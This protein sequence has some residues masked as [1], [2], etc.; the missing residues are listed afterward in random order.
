MV[1]RDDAEETKRECAIH[2]ATDEF[3]SE[4][5]SSALRDKDME[6]SEYAASKMRCP[7]EKT[8]ALREIAVRYYEDRDIVAGQRTAAAAAKYLRE[9]EEGTG[10]ARVSLTLATALLRFDPANAQ[11]AFRGAVAS[12]NKLPRAKD[13]EEKRFY[14]SLLPLADDVI[15]AFRT[16]GWQDREAALALSVEIRLEELRA[17][18]AAGIDSNLRP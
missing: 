9:A 2:S 12:I 4:I 13:E 18:A 16:L 3:L 10:K 15:T 1:S 17:S 14:L 6:I 7:L 5:V 11:E 8:N